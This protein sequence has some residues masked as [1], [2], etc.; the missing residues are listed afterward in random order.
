[1]PKLPVDVILCKHCKRES[2]RTVEFGLDCKVKE[3][4]TQSTLEPFIDP[5]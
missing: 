4:I 3:N 2:E 5:E 1:M